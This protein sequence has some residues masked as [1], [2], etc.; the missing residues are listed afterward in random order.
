MRKIATLRF[1]YG[2]SVIS[3]AGA[4]GLISFAARRRWYSTSSSRSLPC[5][6]ITSAIA[7]IPMMLA[8]IVIS[9]TSTM[10]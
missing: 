7:K 3:P 8:G 5:V 1:A 9:I 2:S 4:G 6:F 10:S